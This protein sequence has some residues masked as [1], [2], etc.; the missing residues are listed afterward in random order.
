VLDALREQLLEPSASNASA[1]R[2]A[3]QRLVGGNHLAGLMTPQGR[4][5][6][7]RLYLPDNHRLPRLSLLDR[8]GIAL[9]IADSDTP[10]QGLNDMVIAWLVTDFGRCGQTSPGT[11]IIDPRFVFRL[12]A[13]DESGT[14]DTESRLV[15]LVRQLGRQLDA[16]GLI[17]DA[18][19]PFKPLT[20]NEVA[21]LLD[22]LG[23]ISDG[24]VGDALHF[25]AGG[26]CEILVPLLAEL[27]PPP[28]AG[29]AR[30]YELDVP[31]LNKA[32]D[33]GAWRAAALRDLL[34]P[35]RGQSAALAAS[36]VLTWVAA[37]FHDGPF[38]V[39]N[40]PAEVGLL[41]VSEEQAG[42]FRRHADLEQATRQLL[43]VGIFEP[44]DQGGCQ[45]PGNGIREMLAGVWP[46]HD[47]VALARDAIEAWF[48]HH[49]W[50]AA[51]SRA[52]LSDRVVRT[53]GHRIANVL[54]A[55]KSA[56][57]RNEAEH[58]WRIVVDRVDSVHTRYR[59]ALSGEDVLPLWDFLS[60]CKGETEF[61][62]P[63]FR[64]TLPAEEDVAGLYVEANGW[65]LGQAFQNLFDNSRQAFEATGREFGE[66][67]VA[68]TVIQPS[69]DGAE[70]TCRIDI[71][72]DGTGIDARVRVKF[73]ADEIYSTWGGRGTGLKT[74]R[75]WFK[76]YR[77]NLDLVVG[78]SALGGAWVR[79]T[80]PLAAPVAANEPA[81]SGSS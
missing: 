16:Q 31:M 68:V 7:G 35:L 11:M 81:N 63:A 42:T 61:M 44:A 52:E 47:Q 45:L 1:L 56:H 43:R 77:G 8:D 9:W 32:W 15:N 14:V 57:A 28:V 53:I 36:L 30:H 38:A 46:G 3:L 79:I 72:D 41:A 69:S 29:R 62:Q 78:R 67:R 37:A 5:W 73:K 2:N 23:V 17:G 10:P 64:V 40:L 33:S 19:P 34:E 48:Q 24:V 59:Q 4:A 18:Q 20:E 50:A 76:E 74:A 13:P 49:E 26:R 27:L 51:Q 75:Q 6:V 12:L 71:E 65:L 66:A 80:L 60:D 25:D 55:A 21:W 58:A 22:L 70:R 54:A 39:E